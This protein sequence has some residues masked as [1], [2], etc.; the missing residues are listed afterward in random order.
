MEGSLL[1]ITYAFGFLFWRSQVAMG[2]TTWYALPDGSGMHLSRA[3]YW[4]VFVSIP[5][6]QFIWLR[7]Y[8]RLVIWF[9]LL[10]RISRLNLRLS[11]AHPDRSG[12]I[13]FLGLGSYAFGPIL[14]AEG[15]WL[16]GV[17][18]SRVLHEKQA[19]MSFKAEAAGFVL[20][21]VLIILGPLLMFTPRLSRVGWQGH[22]DYGL[23]ANRYVFGFEQKWIKGQTPE[24]SELLGTGDLQSL[25][26]LGNS[27]AVVD[28]MCLFP[29]GPREVTR[30]LILTAAP[31]APLLLTT[32]SAQELFNHLIQFL[33]K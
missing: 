19:L 6:F 33:L 18:A 24:A 1:A 29:F 16:A 9:W 27:Y 23:L 13:R 2:V 20:L 30:L 22:T 5:L 14:F 7:W 32:F 10:W 17:I 11:A 21:F 26:D 28:Q 3:G 25:A 8:M 31:L 4:L 12:G 15:A